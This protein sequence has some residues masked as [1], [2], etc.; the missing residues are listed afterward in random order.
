M[1]QQTIADEVGC[2]QSLVS[3]LLSGDRGKNLSYAIG[4]ALI[5]LETRTRESQLD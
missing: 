4:S 2:S 1:T 3:A 5:E